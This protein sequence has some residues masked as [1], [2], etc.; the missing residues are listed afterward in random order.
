MEPANGAVS[1]LS[2]QL[3]IWQVTYRK[4]AGDKNQ[5]LGCEISDSQTLVEGVGCSLDTMR[6]CP[7][8]HLCR[9]AGALLVV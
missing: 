5:P 1:A 6:S 8:L 2:E 9:T 3:W 7:R 4:P